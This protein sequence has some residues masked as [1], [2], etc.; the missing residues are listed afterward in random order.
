MHVFLSIFYG[1]LKIFLNF[2]K[3]QR[4]ISIE[5]LRPLIYYRPQREKKS[6]LRF[7]KVSV[8]IILRTQIKARAE[9]VHFAKEKFMKEFI[10]AKE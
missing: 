9:A 4:E 3:N 5:K 2:C 1:S 8:T 10:E 6:K 7:F